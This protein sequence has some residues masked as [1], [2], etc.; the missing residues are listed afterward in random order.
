[1]K[2][3]LPFQRLILL[4]LAGVVVAGVAYF[5]NGDRTGLE[6]RAAALEAQAKNP[7]TAGRVWSM[8]GG[9][10]Q[11][12]MVN[13]AERDLPAEFDPKSG[14]NIKWAV[15][16]G[17]QSYG[18]P[19]VSGGKV[20]LGTNNAGLRNPRDGRKRAGG[21]PLPEDKGILMCLRESDGKFLWQAVHDKLASGRVNDWPEQ[22]VCSSPFVE[23][24]RVYYVSNRCELVCADVEGFANG[25]QGIQTEKY[26]DPTDADFIWVLD[27][28]DELGVFPHNLAVCSPII[29]GDLVFILT[30]N[31][32]DESHENIPS[33]RAP[34]FIAVDKNNGKVIWEDASPGEKILHGQ[35]SNPSYCEVSGT[36][37]AL[38]AGGDGWV[39]AFE[40]K[41][42]KL[43][44]KF[45]LN[46]KSAV[47][48]LGGRG[49]RNYVIAMPVIHEGLMYIAS[50]QDPEHGEGIGHFWCVDLKKAVEFGKTNKDNDVSPVDDNFDPKAAQNKNSALVWH[51]GGAD[52]KGQLI[53]CRTLSSA[54][55]HEG[56]CYIADL[57][58]IVYCFDAKTGEK[59]W[60][61]DTLTDIWGSPYLVDGKVHVCTNDGYVYVLA[62]GK[63]K[64]LLAKNDVLT[65]ASSTPIA[66]NGTLYVMT[67]SHLYAIGKK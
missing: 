20:F 2:R 4:L 17:S 43:L 46:P 47:Y 65:A 28:M 6:S 58:G 61:H 24:D 25:N 45:D 13:L 33:P 11:R 52:N 42:G 9:S 38:F 59:I 37:M 55:V 5:A 40:P 19:V 51:V 53:F 50:G 66:A 35:W 1:M 22:G 49:T 7:E 34:S 18:N 48:K 64:K 8:F 3:L 44:W 57:R 60:E 27:M 21:K 10:L 31:G 26:K 54:A 56:L 23:G 39:R 67:R 14:K 15:S 12:N 16:I 29:V 63:G 36:P 41:T 30:G 32:H 62:A